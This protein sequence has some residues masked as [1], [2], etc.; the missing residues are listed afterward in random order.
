MGCMNTPVSANQARVVF[1]ELRQSVEKFVKEKIASPLVNFHF[2]PSDQFFLNRSGRPSLRL[3]VELAKDCQSISAVTSNSPTT[4]GRFD[5]H[6]L[7]DVSVHLFNG[8]RKI[9]VEEA[10][11]LL[12]EPFLNSQAIAATN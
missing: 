11:G 12:L 1:T 6:L 5:L 7:A 2:V 9:T 8:T 10:T 4:I 3:T